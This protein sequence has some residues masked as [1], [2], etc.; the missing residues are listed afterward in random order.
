MAIPAISVVGAR[1]NNLQNVSLDIP[2]DR[3]VVVTGLSGSGKSSLAFDTIYAEGQRRYVESLSAYA[4]QFLEQMQKPDVERIDGL[5]P[6][7]SIEQRSG[8]GTPRSTVATQTE[9]FDYLRV[10]FARVGTPHCWKCG[11]PIDRQSAAR[12]IETLSAW[13]AGTRC[14]L[15]APIVRGRK[16]EHRDIFSRIRREGFVRVRVNGRMC[17]L[18]DVPDLEKHRKHT[19]EAVIDRL[20]LGKTDRPRL[21]DSVETALRIGEGVLVAVRDDGHSTA[22]ILC[23][24]RYACPRCGIS[25]EELAPRSFSF[26]SPY[27]ACP[28]CDGLGTKMEL[29][30]D[31][32]VPDKTLSLR[33][34]A[35][36]A[37][38]KAGR[39]MAIYYSRVLREFCG[40]FEVP[41]DVPF[42]K[43]SDPQRRLLLH[44]SQP[45]DEARHGAAFEGVIP[46]LERRFASTESDYIKRKILEYMSELPCPTCKGSRLRKE[47]L[48]VRVG[49]K[50]I[51]EVTACTVEEVLRWADGLVLNE[52]Q[53][54]IAAGVLKEIRARTGFLA[55]V[56][57]GYL[58]LD[59]RS[60]TLSG[61]EAQ[62]IRLASQVGS[63]LVGVCYVLDEPTIGLHQRDNVRLLSTLEHLRDLG[64]TVIVV[65]H[66]EDTIR[67]A[68]HLVDIGP[69]AGLHGGRV[70]AAGPRDEVLRNRASLTAQYLTGALSIPVPKMRRPSAPEASIEVRGARENNLK[71]IDVKVPLGCF[72]CVTGVSGSGKSTLVNEILYK[73]LMRRL[74][75]S[76]ERPGAHDRI[77]CGSALEK[78]IVIDQSPIGRTPRS[79]PATYTGAF[80]EV[81]RLYAMVKEARMR[82]YSPGRFSFNL[83]G[84]RCEACEGQGQKVIEMHFLPDVYVTCEECKGKR[85]NRETLEVKYKGK[86][87]ADVLA[88]PIEEALRFFDAFP[89]IQRV[90]ATLDAV[91]L[92]YV[93]VGQASTTLSGGEAQRVK[94]AAELGKTSGGQTLYILDEP[95]TGLHFADISKLLEVLNQLVS[96]GNT[97]L[98]IE[99][100]MHVIKTADWVIDLGP[101]GGEKGGQVVACGTPE[102]L[103]REER[104]H[105]GQHLRPYLRNG[106]KTGNGVGRAPRGRSASSAPAV[107][108][109]SPASG[110]AGLSASVPS[111]GVAREPADRP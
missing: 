91:G 44:G 69:G 3:L 92:G 51:Q 50:N 25:L 40:T 13:P 7:I 82:G 17:E 49:G 29:D 110:G 60:A 102:S 94:L 27:G 74:Y 5:P 80:D 4:R 87:I 39:R 11:D 89:K 90:L 45:E 20:E 23:S 93:A 86:S 55:D 14:T 1:E 77:L 81:R 34:G 36:E 67:A 37:W 95:T 48:A 47:S 19:I 63:G 21:A 65:E 72:V 46:S 8:T 109:A 66:D 28:T 26:N 103:S 71:R 83:K 30:I 108:S 33:A 58:T 105:T 31:L 15:L 38:R 43:L 64:N 111:S 97:V 68:D 56:G 96:L 70:V 22:D 24:E 52:E 104:S 54:T 99:H 9:I 85:Y 35:I 41:M 84:G 78:V 88:M 59:R 12:I 57:L 98:V 42:Q 18:K 62:R 32:I 2:R 73:G 61:G 107:V 16:G 75:G 100:N 53:K 6:T 106:Q 10:L 76:R 79:N 101:E